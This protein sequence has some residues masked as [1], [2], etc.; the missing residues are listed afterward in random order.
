ML[1]WR[2]DIR[3]YDVKEVLYT[4]NMQAFL[5]AALFRPLIRRRTVIFRKR[6]GLTLVGWQI[7]AAS[8]KKQSATYQEHNHRG[9]SAMPSNLVRMLSHRNTRSGN[10]HVESEIHPAS[11]EAGHST[12]RHE[13]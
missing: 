9:H 1:L 13:H 12:K 7:L 4:P 3:R 6:Q 10:D 2:D 11:Y 5:V 8:I